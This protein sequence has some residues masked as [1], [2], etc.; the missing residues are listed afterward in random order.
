MFASKADSKAAD[1][2]PR[3]DAPKHSRPTNLQRAVG[4]Q[5]TQRLLAQ[6]ASAP[7]RGDNDAAQGLGLSTAVPP[8]AITNALRAAIA[9]ATA[10]GPDGGAVVLPDLIMPIDLV[11]TEQDGGVPSGGTAV[12]APPAAPPAPVPPAPTPAPVSPAPSAGPATPAPAPPPP[13][14]APAPAPA[15]PVAKPVKA[16]LTYSPSVSQAGTVEFF[17]ET[18]WNRF[19]MTGQTVGNDPAAFNVS[20]TVENPIKFNIASGGR[21]DIT[22]DGDPHLTSANYAS[23]A[24]DL[25]PN[26]SDMKGRP[27][28]RNFWASDLTVAHEQFHVAERKI[29]G[30]EGVTDAQTWLNA[31]TASSVADVQNLLAHVPA[32][33][34]ATSKAA[35]TMPGKEERAYTAGAPLYTARAAAIKTKGDAGSYPAPPAAPGS[36]AP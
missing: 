18:N 36:A 22:S 11:E 8:G 21:T 29:H 9:P 13:S 24:R 14:P 7:E 31:Q 6:R 35:M 25:T 34:V 27:P 20:A 5:A 30:A 23:A 26:M 10:V 1:D 12:A 17:G 15:A 33:V 4:N 32:K 19:N 2:A 3:A 28:R 16:A